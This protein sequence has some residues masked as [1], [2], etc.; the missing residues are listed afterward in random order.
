M[1]IV[2]KPLGWTPNQLINTIKKKHP[3]YENIKMS[4]AGRLDPMA[5]GLM[6]ILLDKECKTQDLMLS[7]RKKYRFQLL[8]GVDSDTGDIL[9]LPKVLTD[10]IKLPSN[11]NIS[12]VIE[13]FQGR[14]YQTYPNYSSIYVTSRKGERQPLWKWTKENRLSEIDIPGKDI[15]IYQLSILRKYNINSDDLY[16]IIINKLSNN[17]HG[18]FRKEYILE[19]W[20]NLL[21][22]GK[23]D[24]RHL[25]KIVEI[26][27]E[28]SSGTY[29]RSLCQQIGEKLNCGGLAFDI[30]RISIDNIKN[31]NFYLIN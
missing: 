10:T 23:Y 24:K 27:T 1:L 12:E 20:K 6:L 30:D 11:Q 8:L 31:P 25:W 17:T 22:S 2:K 15:Y 9:G 26:E 29:I 21:L 14:M 3:E 5:R 18:D 16:Y 19:E 7:K 28:V 13:S 4:Y